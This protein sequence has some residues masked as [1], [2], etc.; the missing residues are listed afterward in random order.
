MAR[1]ILGIG[2]SHTPQLST[3]ID[4]WEDHAKRDQSNPNLLGRDGEMHVY[5]ELLSHTEW[6][7]DAARLTP[8]VWQEAH[9]RSQDGVAHLSKALQDANPDAIVVIGD[10]QNEL[11][12]S[13]G[14]PTFAIYWGE[15]I[16]DFAPDEHKQQT[17]AAG[18]RAA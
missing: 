4:W 17:M 6:N 12:L 7:V 5:D 11:F 8:E 2:S 9:Q 15:T 14:T 13:D 16:D 10:D 3:S 1:I 18:L